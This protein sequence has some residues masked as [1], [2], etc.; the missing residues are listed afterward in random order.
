MQ[1]SDGG[2]FFVES[3]SSAQ[4]MVPMAFDHNSVSAGYSGG[5]VYAGGKVSNALLYASRL[6][7][8]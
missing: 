2:V 8:R 4:F 6:R 7:K 1:E 5:A 3:G